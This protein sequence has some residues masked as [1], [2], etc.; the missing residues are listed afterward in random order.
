MLARA[1][2]PFVLSSGL[3][4][5]PASRTLAD[6]VTLSPNREG[7]ARGRPSLATV[8]GD[9]RD[10]EAVD[11][12]EFLALIA[13]LR[14]ALRSFAAVTLETRQRR[15]LLPSADSKAM[16][17][18][19]EEA[20]CAGA[21]SAQPIHDAYSTAAARGPLRFSPSHSSP[22]AIGLLLFFV[23]VIGARS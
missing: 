2:R 19:A 8:A 11:D 7:I 5:R 15:G 4:L 1:V 22:T 9:D 14:D 18:I 23:H 10:A 12:E 21:W 3:L 17:E 13:P 20:S 16:C 6:A